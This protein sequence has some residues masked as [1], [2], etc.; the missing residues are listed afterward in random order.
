MTDLGKVLI[1]LGALLALAG[2]LLVAADKLPG[3]RW[4]GRLPGDIVVRR[5]DFV[6]VFPLA[7]CLVLSAVVSLL[8]YWL[9][10]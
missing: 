3:L 9:R 5:D 6:F 7:T 1:A 4:L 8:L 2:A 10:R